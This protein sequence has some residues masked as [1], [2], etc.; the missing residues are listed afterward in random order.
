M[1]MYIMIAVTE[2]LKHLALAL[3]NIKRDLFGI[4]WEA[5]LYDEFDKQSR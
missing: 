3:N 4:V 5:Q 1:S 2:N